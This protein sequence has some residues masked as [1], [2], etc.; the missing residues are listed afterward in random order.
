MQVISN[1]LYIMYYTVILYGFSQ[2]N[3]GGCRLWIGFHIMLI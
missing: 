3:L 2:V 1:N